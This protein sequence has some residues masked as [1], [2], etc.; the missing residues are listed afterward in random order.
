MILKAICMPKSHDGERYEIAGDF[1]IRKL[2][3]LVKNNNVVYQRSLTK[4]LGDLHTAD[5][6]LC[7]WTDMSDM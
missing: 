7:Y 6:R 1:L 5:L 3:A 2:S 4:Q